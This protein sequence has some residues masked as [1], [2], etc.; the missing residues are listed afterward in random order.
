MLQALAGFVNYFVIMMMNGFLPSLLVGLRLR[1]DDRSNGQL[2]DS[3]GQEW[4]RLL[5]EKKRTAALP[6]SELPFDENTIFNCVFLLSSIKPIVYRNAGMIQ[7][8]VGFINYFVIMATNG[9][10]PSRLINLR[11]FWD[12]HDNNQVMDSYGQEWVRMCGCES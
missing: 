1:W 11:L 7:A 5:T 12:D 10:Y 3:Y 9:W 2:E 6:R 4:V 8:L